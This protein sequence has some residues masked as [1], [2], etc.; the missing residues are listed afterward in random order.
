LVPTNSTSSPREVASTTALNAAL[1][2]LTVWVRSMM[3]MP[4]RAPKM[5]CFIFGFQRPVLWPKWTP[6]SSS[7]RIAIGVD[8]VASCIVS[9]VVL[10]FFRWASGASSDP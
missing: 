4:L 7:W 8:E 2:S 6:A 3:W 1:N 5:Y 9:M 10:A